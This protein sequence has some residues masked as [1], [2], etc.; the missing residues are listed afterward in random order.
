MFGRVGP[1]RKRQTAAETNPFRSREPK[2]PERTLCASCGAALSV[3]PGAGRRKSFCPTCRPAK[4]QRSFASEAKRQAE[5]AAWIAGNTFALKPHL[6]SAP[7]PDALTAP[8]PRTTA[9]ICQG[10]GG[11]FWASKRAAYCSGACRHRALGGKTRTER[12]AAKRA[13]SPCHRDHTCEHC[14]AIF[15][16]KRTDRLRFCC[17]DCAFAA[18]RRST[19]PAAPVP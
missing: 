18:K 10:C 6:T 17:R 1:Y 8:R 9:N 3:L 5:R 2:A 16:P 19:E 11:V 4:R 7:P 14:S 15:R 13:T 12:L